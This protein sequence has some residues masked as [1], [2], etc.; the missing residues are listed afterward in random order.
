M[1]PIPNNTTDIVIDEPL[2]KS[3]KR[4]RTTTDDSGDPE[5]VANIVI[6]AETPVQLMSELIEEVKTL[7]IDEDRDEA[8]NEWTE[9]AKSAVQQFLEVASAEANIAASGVCSTSRASQ[10]PFTLTNSSLINQQM[11]TLVQEKESLQL[12]LDTKQQLLESAQEREKRLEQEKLELKEQL[13]TTQGILSDSTETERLNNLEAQLEEKDKTIK[14]QD[15]RLN[16]AIRARETAIRET[17]AKLVSENDAALEKQNRLLK[18]EA[19]QREEALRTEIEKI[20]KALTESSGQTNYL[21]GLEQQQVRLLKDKEEQVTVQ[22]TKEFNELQTKY[23]SLGN[24]FSETERNSQELKA[25]LNSVELDRDHA[26]EQA[27]ANAERVKAIQEMLDNIQLTTKDTYAQQLQ[28]ENT[29]YLTLFNE[30]EERKSTLEE[31]MR[32]IANLQKDKLLLKEEIGV[33]NEENKLSSAKVERLSNDL[34]ESRTARNALTLQLQASD[35]NLKTANTLLK[36]E[37]ETTTSLQTTLNTQQTDIESQRKTVEALNNDKA[38]LD[39]ANLELQAK[40]KTTADRLKI[41][42][43]ENL[44]KLVNVDALQTAQ[45][46][47]ASIKNQNDILR[48]Q[49]E[50]SKKTI[51]VLLTAEPVVK[52]ITKEIV[53]ESSSVALKSL[54]EEL[55]DIDVYEWM[56]AVNGFLGPYKVFNASEVKEILLFP[57]EVREELKQL[58]S[59]AQKLRGLKL[60]TASGLPRNILDVDPTLASANYILLNLPYYQEIIRQHSLPVIPVKQPIIE[61]DKN[62][63]GGGGDVLMG[64]PVTILTHMDAVN[65]VIWQAR[66]SQ[67][68]D[69]PADYTVEIWFSRGNPFIALTKEL[70]FIVHNVHIIEDPNNNS[71]TR[72]YAI[73]LAKPESLTQ[74]EYIQ[75]GTLFRNAIYGH[76]SVQYRITSTDTKKEIATGSIENYAFPEDD[77]RAYNSEVILSPNEDVRIYARDLKNDTYLMETIL[78]RAK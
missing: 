59:Q 25:Q 6:T 71:G 55:R 45:Q 27:R 76:A 46:E 21:L 65:Q 35:F 49:L 78:I 70:R 28:L 67:L 24:K 66:I 10:A 2:V 32:Q 73:D 9:K 17:K 48:T 41:L 50:E 5:R 22:F 40:L 54:R 15:A 64:A 75:L 74:I 63:V 30:N 4:A 13:D 62:P 52:T 38:Q 20:K 56:K 14:D 43:D 23:N 18:A 11:L 51:E 69:V 8:I 19:S 12:T 77:A 44:D 1:E 72:Y 33:C 29:K 58:V 61:D 36:N 60:Y 7:P 16:E 26:V 42:Q 53:D 31:L 57:L 39:F 68:R 34:V 47:V 3:N 37:K